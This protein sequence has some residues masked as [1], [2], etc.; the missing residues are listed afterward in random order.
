MSSQ[1]DD[2]NAEYLD[3]FESL[4]E[5]IGECALSMQL[6]NFD[7]VNL[8]NGTA[9]KCSQSFVNAEPH[10]EKTWPKDIEYDGK[11]Y[12]F[13]RPVSDDSQASLIFISVDS[14]DRGRK[15]GMLLTQF[16]EILKL[17]ITF[18][19]QNANNATAKIFKVLENYTSE[20]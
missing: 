8:L 13:M 14:D 11:K 12:I 15:R 3:I 10:D 6:T 17:I 1:G 18:D 19:Y 5:D 4:V 2:G 9:G 20:E 7:D 16:C